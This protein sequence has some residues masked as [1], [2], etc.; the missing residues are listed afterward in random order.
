MF[1]KDLSAHCDVLGRAEYNQFII[2]PRTNSR[3]AFA[4]AGSSNQKT[5]LFILPSFSSRLIG[6]PAL[7]PLAEHY[8]V[9]V[10]SIDR[11]GCGGTPRCALKDRLAT[12]SDNTR[13]VLEYLHV[14]PEH[15]AIFTHSAGSVFT[16]ALLNRHPDLFPKSP[17]V[18]VTSGWVPVSISGQL[19]L[20]LVPSALVSHFH[21]VFPI[22]LPLISSVGASLAFS[23]AM[24]GG[25]DAETYAPPDVMRPLASAPITYHPKH[26]FQVSKATNAALLECAAKLESM[27]GVSDEYLLCLGRGEGSIDVD[28]FTDTV[29]KISH[30][31]RQRGGR[32]R[33]ELW[34]GS[35][36]MLIPAK[37]QRWYTELLKDQG[38]VFEVVTFELSAGHDELLTFAEV[39]CPIFEEA[40]TVLST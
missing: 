6:A 31:Y 21:N 9:R 12:A 4:E 34:W 2:C 28:W 5:L 37:G 36:D 15:T 25:A 14:D 39:V 29:R 1:D 7:A 26:T 38:D 19:G 35:K 24:F 22:S 23:K 16:L 10:V 33:F 3:V 17:H 20:N 40:R 32:V 18:F 13:S 27:Q 30:A 8:G 11:P